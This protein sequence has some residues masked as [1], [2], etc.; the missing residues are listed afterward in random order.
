MPACLQQLCRCCCL[1]QYSLPEGQDSIAWL[2]SFFEKLQDA[3]EAAGHSNL[4]LEAQLGLQLPAQSQPFLLVNMHYHADII[5]PTE[6][7]MP[8][9]MFETPN[10]ICTAFAKADLAQRRNVKT[11]I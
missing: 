10:N 11:T 6:R 3:E 4:M 5:M 1:E 2:C 7:P 9:E 8:Q